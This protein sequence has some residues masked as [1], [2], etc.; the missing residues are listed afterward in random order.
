[1]PPVLRHPRFSPTRAVSVAL[2]LG[3]LPLLAPAALK[4]ETVV[5]RAARTGALESY[6]LSDAPPFSSK[7]GD[8]FVGLAPVVL[9]RIR[10][11]VA[12]YLGKPLELRQAEASS[13]DQVIEGIS[14][15]RR[16]VACGAAFNWTREMHLDHTLPFALS[17]IRLLAPAGIDGTPD[18]LRGQRIGV[19]KNSAAALTL[20]EATPAVTLALF[21]NPQ[22]ALAALRSGQVPL[23]GGDSLWLMASRK[24]IGRPL[25]IVPTIPYNR[26]AVSC[27][28]PEGNDTFA[29]LANLAIVKLLQGY[30]DGKEADRDAVNRWVG[31]GSAVDLSE[32]VIT[33]YFNTVL[34]TRQQIYL[35]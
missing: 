11:E 4:A 31:P 15:G 13:V 17:G 19:V 7:Q 25:E 1:M 3:L 35:P 9:A 24:G 30:V 2:V 8:T 23:L 27:I 14:Q 20:A 32:E 22:Q 28:F 33:A 29:N 5:E 6:T 34:L 16:D 10:D 21:D 26:F 18:S 12:D